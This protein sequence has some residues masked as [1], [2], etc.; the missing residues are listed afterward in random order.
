MISCSLRWSEHCLSRIIRRSCSLPRDK[1]QHRSHGP[2]RA[3]A[4]WL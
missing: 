1:L 3:Q 4:Q 2:V